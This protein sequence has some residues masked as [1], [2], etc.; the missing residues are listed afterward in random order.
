MKKILF[1]I[2][3]LSTLFL[4]PIYSE[5]ALVNGYFT[6]D[7]L[8][9]VWD[10]Q[11]AGNW[12]SN[13]W[14]SNPSGGYTDWTTAHRIFGNVDIGETKDLYIAVKNDGAGSSTNPAGFLGSITTNAGYFA[15]TGNNRLLTDISHWEVVAYSNGWTGNPTFDP[16]LLTYTDPTAYGANNNAGTVWYQGNG[17][18]KIN[19]IHNNAQWLW[20]DDNFSTTMDQYAVFH[21]SFSV[22]PEPASMALLGIGLIGI[23]A[24][25]LKRNRK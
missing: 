12:G 18:H 17:N 19:N 4:L 25:R 7:N 23:V 22:V 3:L 10:Y 15:E 1:A 2:I 21:T 14:F 9:W 5:A 24:A 8:F 13:A 16:T 11:G 6:G 20:T